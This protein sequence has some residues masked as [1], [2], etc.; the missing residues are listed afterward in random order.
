MTRMTKVQ[1][2][3]ISSRPARGRMSS[4]FSSLRHHN[5]RLF[6]AGQIVS[7]VGT[8]MQNT[9]QQWLVYELT[10]S[11]ALLGTVAAVGVAPLLFLSTLGGVVAERCPRRSILFVTQSSAM[12]LA[13]VLGS[14][15][16]TGRVQVWHIM[17][18]SALLGTVMAFDIPT[19]QAFVIDLVGA[20]SLASGIALN[21]A[22]FNSARII[23]PALAGLVMA[24]TRRAI[25]TASGTSDFASAAGGI[26]ACFVVNGLTFVA[27]LVALKK[28]RPAASSL[29][30]RESPL[31]TLFGGF[32][33]LWRL[34]HLLAM[35][36]LVAV[37]VVF[38]FSY[39][40][41]LPV[42]AKHQ[43]DPGPL[44]QE[45]LF[46]FML[47]ATGIGAVLGALSV[48]YVGGQ[49]STLRYT[50]FGGVL[51]ASLSIAA[52]SFTTEALP[53]MAALALVGMGLTMFSASSNTT[54]QLQVSNSVRA[55]VMA[56]WTLMFGGMAPF[57]GLEA[58][59]LADWLGA[60]AALRTGSAVVALSAVAV[61]ALTASRWAVG[62]DQQGR[63]VASD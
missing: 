6:F 5:Y 61:L 12:L 40:V 20:E 15:V 8:W 46:G 41:L 14:L 25:S 43:I 19:R 50:L 26:G 22:T 45:A 35:L 58:G 52:F 17:V 31:K 23:G 2:M 4:T 55:R 18:I 32:I 53:A 57:G 28:I 48:A 38:G 47:T 33:E 42:F 36:A 62:S 24:G 59:W 3:R 29:S 56:V 21:S 60:P 44:S 27:V 7:L 13:F 49:K 37:T 54:L 11:E 1:D 16:L 10:G 30:P 39:T 51:L 9:A 34:K 63:L